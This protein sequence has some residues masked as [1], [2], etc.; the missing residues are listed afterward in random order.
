MPVI[1][2]PPSR[3]T[4]TSACEKVRV[5]LNNDRAAKLIAALPQRSKRTRYPRSSATFFGQ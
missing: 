4:G 3:S 2:D 5:D 1:K